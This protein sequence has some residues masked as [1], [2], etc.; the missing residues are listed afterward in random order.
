MVIAMSSR[1]PGLHPLVGLAAL[2]L[3]ASAAVAAPS[4]PPPAATSVAP[5]RDAPP[6]APAGHRWSVETEAIQP[7]VPTVGIARVR[8][9]RQLWG[10]V[11]GAHG[12]LVAGAYL[13]PGV[14]HDVVE[15]IDEYMA[16]VGVRYFAWR[17][18]H[19]EALL[20]AGVAWGTNKLDHM[21]YRTPTLFAEVNLGYRL[22]LFAPGGLAGAPRAVGFH[23]TPQVGVLSSL[24]LANDIGPRNGKPDHF[25]TAALLLGASF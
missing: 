22:S 21:D 24:G 15:T 12:D 17:G 18:L 13:R 3:G 8:V 10:E 11:A 2:G 1:L 7:F 20:D 6:A 14:E 19:A 25:L 16:T 5:A 9:T 4:S 23:V